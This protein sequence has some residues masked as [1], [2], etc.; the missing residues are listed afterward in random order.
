MSKSIEVYGGAYKVRKT[1]SGWVIESTG[2]DP[3][4]N[5]LIQGALRDHEVLYKK[6]TL[7]NHGINYND[8]PAA[9]WNE[10]INNTQYLTESVQPDRI[11][12][13]GQRV[14]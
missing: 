10:H 4:Y 14:Q 12:K 1:Q 6:E 11:L 2:Y 5:A 3:H 8:D 7:E 9:A 13:T